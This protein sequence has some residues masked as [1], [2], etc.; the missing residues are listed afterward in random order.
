MLSVRFHHDFLRNNKAVPVSVSSL[1][2]QKE[3]KIMFR[4]RQRFKFD[5][6]S[7]SFLRADKAA[8]VVEGTVAADANPFR[9]MSARNAAAQ[10]ACRAPA[11]R[12]LLHK[13]WLDL[14]TKDAQHGFAKQ[15]EGHTLLL[16]Q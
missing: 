14:A 10:A 16:C 5:H 15:T 12:Q 2:R 3:C 4:Q 9:L 11:L 1:L 7:S 6:M 13:N 8:S